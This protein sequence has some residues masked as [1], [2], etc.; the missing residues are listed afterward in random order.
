[1]PHREK[2]SGVDWDAGASA[3]A[4]ADAGGETGSMAQECPD[5][6]VYEEDRYHHM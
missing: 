4:L 5:G 6:G 2:V 1:M 3:L